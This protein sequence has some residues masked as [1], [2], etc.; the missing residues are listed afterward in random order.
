MEVAMQ[1][2]IIKLCADS[3]RSFTLEKY[4]ITLKAAH[5]HEL[6]AAYFGYSSKNAMLADKLHPLEKLEHSSIFVMAPDVF[7]DQ[8]RKELEGLSANLPDSYSL[9]EGVYA[10]LISD[11]WWKNSPWP[12]FRSFEKMAAYFADEDVRKR[13]PAGAYKNHVS[14]DIKITHT[15]SEVEIILF[16]FYRVPNVDGVQEATITTTIKLP[17]LAGHIGYGRAHISVELEPLGIKAA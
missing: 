6:T 10:V 2:D 5:A 16:R 17:R 12:P 1:H 14:E 3:L 11:P 4:G 7:I 8:R 9:G 15:E 13:G